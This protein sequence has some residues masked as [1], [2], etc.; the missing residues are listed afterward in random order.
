MASTCWSC[1]EGVVVADPDSGLLVCTSCG[2]VHDSGATEFVH[3]AAYTDDGGF[4]IRVSSFVYHQSQSHYRDQKLAAAAI[5]ITSI[6][7]RLGLSPTRA[8]EALSMAKSATDGNLATQGTAFLPALASACAFLVARSY[9]LPLSLAEAAETAFCPTASLADLVSRIASHLSL[10]PLPSFDYAA[11]L[12]RAVRS[13][14]SISSA[15]C[16]R[17]DVILSQARFLLRCA[18]KWSLTTG[19]NPLPLIAGLVAFAAQ[20]NGVTS[21]S[22][23]DIARDISANLHTSLRRYKELVDALVHVA[24]KLLPWGADVN[25]KNLLLNAPVLLRLME[26]RSQ[27]DLL[28]QFLESFTPDIAGIVQ[29]YSSIDEDESKYL[30]IVPLAV[31]DLDSNNS[32]QEG[33]ESDDL[34]ISEECLSG[35][36]QNVLKRLGQLQRLG[37]V[38]KDANRRKQWRRGL[39]LEPWMDSLDDGWTKGMVLEDLVNIDIGFD[40]PP[41]SFTAGIKLQKQRRIRI[42]AAKCRIDAIRKAPAGNENDLQVVLRNEDA[43][44]PQNLAKKKRG[45]KRITRSGDAMHGELLTDIPD[46][47]GGGKKRRKGSPSDGIDWEDCIIELL[48]LHGANEEEIEQ[49]QYRRLLELHV[50]TAV[51]G[52]R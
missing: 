2:R 27:S 38:G 31:D 10:P 7:A 11:A 39:E 50:F 40:A 52:G 12:E 44:L 16:E 1:G 37:Q 13:S 23:E 24:K 6:A 29:A 17:T 47:A 25:T 46:G 36:Y 14:P 15:A 18:S 22:V 42:E 45:K 51:R 48:L 35:A 41:P 4:D 30:Q 33:K 8:E 9:R 19:R 20:A 26:M 21:V 32:G 49:G 5:T 34:R 43:C 28:E 3:Q